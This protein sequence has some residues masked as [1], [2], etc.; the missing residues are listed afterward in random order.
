MLLKDECKK[1][2]I[3]V[4]DF[5]LAVGTP[6]RTLQDWTVKH[7]LRVKAFLDAM[8]YRTTE[9]PDT[10][11][12][13]QTDI[14]AD[15]ISNDS[16]V[17][18]VVAYIFNAIWDRTRFKCLPHDHD[19]K[20]RQLCVIPRKEFSSKVCLDVLAVV[21]EVAANNNKVG[22]YDAVDVVKHISDMW[23]KHTTK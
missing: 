13:L 15:D 16:A 17:K 23:V 12:H 7:P 21:R 5:A 14:F 9:R 10:D 4:S 2:N 6:V 1:L 3:K 19:V 22:N 18:S 8:R 11:L 20:G